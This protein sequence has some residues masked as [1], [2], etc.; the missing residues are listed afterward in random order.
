MLGNRAMAQ[1]IQAKLTVSHPNDPYEREADRVADTVMR[2]P[3][4]EASE[5]EAT[6]IQP[7]SLGP[8][9][10]PLVQR[11]SEVDEEEA[12]AAQPALQRQLA[13]GGEDEEEAVVATKPLIHRLPEPVL[14]EGAEEEAGGANPSVQRMQ[15]PDAE[16]EEA[17]GVTTTPFIQRQAQ[18]EEAVQGKSLP[19]QV[20]R[21]SI[22]LQRVCSAC[23]AELRQQPATEDPR[24]QTTPVAGQPV[25]AQ[26]S[27]GHPPGGRA[28]APP[29]TPA[30]AANIQAL[31][32]GGSPLSQ[33][34]RA[35]FEPR[36]GADFS[37]VRVHTDARA[38]H[39]THSVHAR[40]FTVGRNIAFGTGQYA[41]HAH[42]GRQVLAH[43]LTHVVQQHGRQPQ[44]VQTHLKP[45]SVVMR[46]E[47][48]GAIEEYKQPGWTSV[49]KL[50][51]VRVEETEAKE[52]GA[53]L[54][55]SP[56]TS[57][58]SLV[59]LEENTKVFV[60][61]RNPASK[62]PIWIYVNVPSLSSFGYIAEHLVWMGLPDPDAQ[63]FYVGEKG[64]GLQ[65]LVESPKH[66]KLKNADY[67]QNYIETGDDARSLVMAIYTA[68]EQDNRTK[69]HVYINQAKLKE[70]QNPGA[71]EGLKD[72]ADEYRRVLRPILQSVEVLHGQKIWVPGEAYIKSLKDKE[73][74]PTR[75]EW[76]NVAIAAAKGIGGFLAGLVDGFF[77][78]II[79]V[80][81]GIYDLIKSVISLVMDLLSGELIRQA[82]EIY[83]QVSSMSASELVK[84]LKDAVTMIISEMFSDF[85]KRWCSNNVYE[86]WYFRGQI[87]G[88]IAA[89]VLMAI[90]TAGA[91]TAVKWLGKLGKLGGK[92]AQVLGKILKKVDDA[93]DK[94]PGRKGRKRDA[95]DDKDASS[96]KAKQLP[97]ALS[98]AAAIAETNDA[99]DSPVPVVLALLRP[100][101]KKFTW[102]DRFD[103]EKKSPGHYRIL[104]YASPP[105]V[106]DDDYTTEREEEF[107]EEF[108]EAQEKG[109]KTG[110]PEGTKGEIS[111]ETARVKVVH[112]LGVSKG[113]IK[114][115]N[116][117]FSPNN[118]ATGRSWENPYE[119]DG[120]F[121][122]GIDDIMFDKNGDPV[123]LEYKGGRS[124]LGSDQMQKSW[125]CRKIKQLKRLNDPM[126]L[127]LEKAM[128]KGRLKGRLYR[129]PV[130]DEGEAGEPFKEKDWKYKGPCP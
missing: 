102:I 106:V 55:Q 62:W 48:K 125:V 26:A 126:A 36:F 68:N 89:E 10:T 100:L 16:A 129:T 77:S 113:K 56:S 35:F 120:P 64:M 21:P 9:I 127:T 123:I 39:T 5:D 117:G 8:R 88:Y 108:K 112:D 53:R 124:E 63:L 59:H 19:S 83:D 1:F 79:E 27:V 45:S 69:G 13:E 107:K 96:D 7:Q 128:L 101:K 67:L 29:V 115:V 17:N 41:P 42:A 110:K 76:K 111:A 122:K 31:E 92:L 43:E 82:E 58:K 40:A 2:M 103:D 119:F 109:V 61:A 91:A 52:R 44:R 121:G 47:A 78:A 65:K 98:M 116:D 71:I 114:A 46:D 75:P 57:S 93:F 84:M 70:A 105:H 80:F 51:I 25:G 99:K 74:I 15:A 6:A 86:S 30:V 60:V 14:E 24:V 94:V 97:I 38:A 85:I 3:E 20:P 66:Y 90:F 118:P 34:T 37:Q 22:H 23:D 54:R 50:G 32:G 87:V 11:A 72:R 104:M 130:S 95:K 12:I 33:A 18:E 28:H 73:I 81:T 49:N 4:P